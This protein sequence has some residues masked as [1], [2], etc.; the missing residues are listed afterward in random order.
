MSRTARK[1]WYKAKK[2]YKLSLTEGV[3]RAFK[4]P[5]EAFEARTQPEP[6]SGCL[7]WMGGLDHAGYGKLKVN[8]KSMKAHRF[9][10]I[11]AN[12]EIPKGKGYH[13]TCVLH[14]C[15]NPLCCN[16]SHL[17]LGTMSDNNLDRTK[18]GRTVSGV[19]HHN[20][21]LTE[22]DVIT[23]RADQRIQ[24]EIAKDYKISQPQVSKIKQ[25]KIWKH[26]KE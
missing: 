10:W 21:H 13:G 2:V 26:I 16:P 5:E 24:S 3:H 25:K 23:I 7:L 22:K 8:G 17:F 4:T 1:T 11:K 18:K 19:K 14:R 9:A 6:N 12:G 15:D 20:T